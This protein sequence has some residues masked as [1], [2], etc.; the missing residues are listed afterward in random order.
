MDVPKARLIHE[1]FFGHTRIHP[2]HCLAG[3]PRSR[4][5]Q[6]QGRDRSLPFSSQK[7]GID[8]EGQNDDG[9]NRERHHPDDRRVDATT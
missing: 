9:K 5:G 4:L 8:Q 1:P 6:L 2:V 7:N 3:L